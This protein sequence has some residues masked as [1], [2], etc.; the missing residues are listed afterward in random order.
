[1]FKTREDEHAYRFGDHGPKYLVR[2]PRIDVGVVTLQPG[3]HF[4]T[5]KH[6]HVEENFL[7][8]AGEVHM[9]VDGELHVLGVGDF[10]R[11]EPGEGHHVVNRG[12]TPWKA[13][14]IKSPYDPKD[15]VPIAWSPED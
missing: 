13:V 2:G 5:H 9:Y 7:T 10:L 8:I 1:M 6:Q 14:F 4:S 12:D 11:C 3:Q 15:S